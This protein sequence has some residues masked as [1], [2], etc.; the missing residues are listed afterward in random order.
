MTSEER[1]TKIEKM[2]LEEANLML[3]LYDLEY[4]ITGMVKEREALERQEFNGNTRVDIINRLGVDP[5]TGM[6]H[7]QIENALLKSL[8]RE[9]SYSDPMLS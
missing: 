7:I 2:W 8:G 1:K 9:G 4:K 5:L 3:D 6:T